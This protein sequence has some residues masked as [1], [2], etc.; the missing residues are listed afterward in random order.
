MFRAIAAAAL[1]RA[2]ALR[3][4]QL[5]EYRSGIPSQF[6]FF[7]PAFLF[8]DLRGKTMAFHTSTHTPS[9]HELVVARISIALAVIITAF[10]S[11]YIAQTQLQ[12]YQ[13][14]PEQIPIADMNVWNALGK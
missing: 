13:I 14:A 8:A 1:V 5:K 9:P 2:I 12:R 6:E 3:W 7:Q 10:V 11:V 4:R